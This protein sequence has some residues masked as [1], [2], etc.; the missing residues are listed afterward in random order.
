MGFE[1]IS[2]FISET[3]QTLNNKSYSVVENC[4]LEDSQIPMF[5]NIGNTY[6]RSIDKNFQITVDYE[7]LSE[8][9]FR[10]AKYLF[11][12]RGQ[13][14]IDE[15]IDYDEVLYDLSSL[16]LLLDNLIK[17]HQE[18][19]PGK[20][21]KKYDRLWAQ[22]IGEYN[23]IPLHN[24]IQGRYSRFLKPLYKLVSEE[25][26]G[27]SKKQRQAFI[28]LFFPS[29]IKEPI[30]WNGPIYDLRR[31]LDLLIEF[32]LIE[33]PIYFNKYVSDNFQIKNRTN[34]Y[35][36][37]DEKSFKTSYNQVG[38]NNPDNYSYWEK[39]VKDISDKLR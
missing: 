26:I 19:T 34:R 8:S 2:E 38:Y 1:E 32:E 17:N 39:K 3:K 25:R 28:S 30:K 10:I 22:F 35:Q 15:T 31:F 20:F 11:T 21:S 7:D 33:K 14:L 6:K 16:K 13:I 5:I 27:N 4:F 23:F 12:I 18:Y 36:E 29:K 9:H 37:F 24:N